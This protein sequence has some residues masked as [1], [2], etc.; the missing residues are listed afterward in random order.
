LKSTLLTLELKRTDLL[1]KFQPDYRLVKEVEKQI[2]DT[3]AD[4]TKAE[5]SPLHEETTDQNPTYSWIYSELAKASADLSGLK[6]REAATERIVQQYEAK[7]R[8]LEQRGI[9]QQD[10]LREAKTAEQNYLLYQQKREQA[11]ITDALDRTQ[12]LNV[13]V[14]EEPVAPVI[15]RHSPMLFG[16]LGTLL[17]L[18]VSVALVFT[19]DYFDQSFRTPREVETVLNLPVLAAVPRNLISSN[20]HGSNGHIGNRGQG[21]GAGNGRNGHNN[22]QNGLSGKQATVYQR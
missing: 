4:L 20:G 16:L 5:Q 6:A 3:R 14:A 13:G 9:G 22:E 2:A 12:I 1:T 10:L 8:D 17:G 18:T 7:A 19:I 15:P 21:V 11:R